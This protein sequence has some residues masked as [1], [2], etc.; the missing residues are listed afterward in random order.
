MIALQIPIPGGETWV[1]FPVIA[2]IVLCFLLAG[3]GIFG[4]TKWIWNQYRAERDKD[5]DWRERQ[6][7]QREAAVA[8]QNRLWREAMAERDVRYEQFDQQRESTVKMLAA[9]IKE[10]AEALKSHDGQA[11][12]IKT[13]V[14]RIDREITRPRTKVD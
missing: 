12:E 13:V 1:Q 14:E 6:N 3:S 9:N 2:V 11:K 10:I 7:A 5:L 4:F 8:E